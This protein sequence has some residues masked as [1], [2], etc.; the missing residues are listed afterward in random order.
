MLLTLLLEARLVRYVSAT[1]R[2]P[3]ILRAN[4]DDDGSF[5]DRERSNIERIRTTMAAER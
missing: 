4:V 5:E 1:L 3:S 2:E